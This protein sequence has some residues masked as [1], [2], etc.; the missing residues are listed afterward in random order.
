[1]YWYLTISIKFD[2]KKKHPNYFVIDVYDLSFSIK[3]DD[4]DWKAAKWWDY[5]MH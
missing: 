5:I 2:S 3:D 1:M 4:H